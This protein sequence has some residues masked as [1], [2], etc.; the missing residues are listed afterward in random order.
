MVDILARRRLGRDSSESEAR[1]MRR[2]YLPAAA[3][4][5][6]SL[7]GWTRGPM[8]STLK[9]FTAGHVPA[10]GPGEETLPQPWP[11]PASLP[12]RPG[13]LQR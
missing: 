2:G 10:L 3:I 9:Q 12:E 13:D 1:T 4:L 8:A 5:A 11:E 6:T 7:P